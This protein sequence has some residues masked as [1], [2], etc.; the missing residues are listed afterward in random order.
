MDANFLYNALV[1]SKNT[2]K[3]NN[4]LEYEEF[5]AINN[6]KDDEMIVNVAGSMVEILTSTSLLLRLSP[7]RLC[8]WYDKRAELYVVDEVGDHY[9][10][11]DYYFVDNDPKYGS[12]RDHP[13]YVL[14]RIDDNSQS[15]PASKK[16]MLEM[17]SIFGIKKTKDH[18]DLS[19]IINNYRLIEKEKAPPGVGYVKGRYVIDI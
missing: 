8:L 9:Y 18:I 3:Q 2:Y 12:L 13:S 4:P 11:V 1:H 5:L 16:L 10:F 14:G 17:L 19:D 15:K 7:T 6:L